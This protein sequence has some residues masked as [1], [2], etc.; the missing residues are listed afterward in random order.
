MI[1]I[2]LK[3]K[4]NNNMNRFTKTG[5]RHE[6]LKSRQFKYIINDSLGSLVP[7]N[8]SELLHE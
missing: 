1:N 6:R 2:Y 3:R 4:K 8:K 5:Y 7:S